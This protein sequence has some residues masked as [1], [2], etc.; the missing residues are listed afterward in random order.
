MVTTIRIMI[1]DNHKVVRDN[2]RESLRFEL[3]MEV[4]CEAAS[5][6]E[7]IKK[8]RMMTPDIIL[9]DVNMPEIDG[10]TV[11]EMIAREVPQCLIIVMS[12]QGGKE[13]LR[14]A[15][16]VGAKDYLLKPFEGDE[17]VNC[18]KHIYGREQKKRER[19]I[20]VIKEPGKVITIFST[21]GGIGKTTMVTNL[22]TELGINSKFKVCII[23]MDLQFGDVPLLLNLVPGRTIADLIKDMDGR[24]KLDGNFLDGYMTKFMDNVKVLAAPFWP[25]EV[26]DVTTDYLTT[27]IKELQHHYDYVI[28]DTAS[29]FNDI[30]FKILDL[31]NRIIAVTSQDVSTLMNVENC[32]EI[33]KS[34]NYPEEKF[35]VVL[36]QANSNVSMNVKQS[37]ELLHRKLLG[38][39]PNDRPTVAAAEYLGIP[40]V[41]N[42]Q[43]TSVAQAIFK[44]AHYV[45]TG[46]KE[47]IVDP[48]PRVS[49]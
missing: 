47:Y 20:H 10:F 14:K 1:V 15:M 42:N 33:L 23:D 12:V 6:E 3:N 32:L 46:D 11:T 48:I 39:M 34:L 27:I 36:S 25:E 18:I 28:I 22:A 30:M 8:A 44:L 24:H 40:F 43:D 26:G 7:A 31:S 9:I 38:C 4:V 29:L 45:I 19:F 16:F 2:I 49:V 41:I 17:L 5:G 21:K 37:E 13:Q 35:Q